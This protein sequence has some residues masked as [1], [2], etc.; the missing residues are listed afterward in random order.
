MVTNQRV[1]PQ[2]RYLSCR[3]RAYIN[4][5]VCA[6][7]KVVKYIHKYVYKGPDQATVAM[8]V[9]AYEVSRHLQGRYIGPT[10]AM[11][12]LFEFPM[13][14]EFPPLQELTVH[15]P[16]NQVVYFNPDLAPD[17]LREKMENARSTLMAF[18]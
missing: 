17:E 6:S 10:E 9:R 2:N 14:E 13:H 15:L 4:V 11:W 1:V 18:F 8:N 5:E 12:R 3:Y 16:G 7:V